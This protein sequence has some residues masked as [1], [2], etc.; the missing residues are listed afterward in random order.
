M[1]VE[2]SDV[3]K[4]SLTLVFCTCGQNDF[5]VSVSGSLYQLQP[6]CIFCL[7]KAPVLVCTY[8]ELCRSSE[9]PDCKVFSTLDVE[10]GGSLLTYG[11]PFPYP[12]VTL[13]HERVE[14]VIEFRVLGILHR[15]IEKFRCS[16]L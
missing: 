7:G 16:A 6:R 1:A 5:S 2:Y 10:V 9:L 12:I 3:G 4:A 13:N 14:P 11:N 8:A 15:H